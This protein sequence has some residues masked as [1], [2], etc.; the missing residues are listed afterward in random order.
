MHAVVTGT[1][2]FVGA[3][4]A[5][6]CLG[7]GL[8]VTAVHRKAPPRRVSAHPKLVKLAM[9]LRR[10]E[11]LPPAYDYLFHCAA[12]VPATCPD[13]DELLNS[14]IEGTRKLLEHAS[15]A[16][17]RH[18][19]FMSSMAVYGDIRVPVVTEDTVPS[20]PSAYGRSKA[21]GESLVQLWAKNTGG[22]AVSIRLP[23][24]VGAGGRNNFLCD[25]LQKILNSQKVNARNAH[26]LFN[27]VVH[28]EDLAKFAV[29]L[30]EHLPRSA[31]AL[32]IAAREPLSIESVLAR[33]YASTG[34]PE[35]ISWTTG[36]TPFQISFERALALGYRPA[37]VADTL[38]RFVAD[39]L[40]E[41]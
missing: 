1:G 30:V 23:G 37:T 39:V 13:P 17:A 14:N 2:G 41:M 21:E 12:D 18:V 40:A 31:S 22:R 11:N 19:V 27:N 7:A 16:G 20:S 35:D 32:T 29:E 8:D 24:I 10:P 9:D 28:V 26:A 4:I 33:L 5:R 25:S 38:Q 6:R 3:A 34:R 36:G 15:A